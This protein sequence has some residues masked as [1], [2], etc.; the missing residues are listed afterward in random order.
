[1]TTASL[2]AMRVARPTADL[3]RIR[4]DRAG[5]RLGRLLEYVLLDRSGDGAVRIHRSAG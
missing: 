2:V 4:S 5:G 1:L 3:D